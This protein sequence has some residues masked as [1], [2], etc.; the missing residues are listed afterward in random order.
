MASRA[1]P[2]DC[3]EFFAARRI[4]AEHFFSLNV[5]HFTA[6]MTWTLMLAECSAMLRQGLAHVVPNRNDAE[7]LVVADKGTLAGHQPH[8]RTE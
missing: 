8:G 2:H 4:S 3:A 1:P 5:A 7:S 6:I